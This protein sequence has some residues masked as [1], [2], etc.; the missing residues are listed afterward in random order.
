MFLLQVEAGTEEI[1]GNA[2]NLIF[3]AGFFLAML[4]VFI[5]WL[6]R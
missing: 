3:M 5:W 2:W 4:G 6:R 1:A